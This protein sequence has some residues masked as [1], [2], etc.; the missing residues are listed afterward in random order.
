MAALT[1]NTTA[2]NGPVAIGEIAYSDPG[3]TLPIKVLTREIDFAKQN[4]K[5]NANYV[6]MPIPKGFF[7]KHIAVEQTG[8]IDAAATLTFAT[9]NDATAA[10]GGDFALVA[11]G[12]LL[13]TIQL[14]T[15]A[16]GNPGGILF[17][18]DDTL[19]VKVPATTD[20]TTGGLRVS[21]IGYMPFGDSAEFGNGTEPMRKGTDDGLDNAASP[22]YDD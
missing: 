21:L 18:A 22:D 4:F 16:D 7:V 1:V 12:T 10:V 13:R 2:S 5:K 15:S 17:A 9:L 14:A 6:F 3:E 20:L 19:C 8:A 11:S